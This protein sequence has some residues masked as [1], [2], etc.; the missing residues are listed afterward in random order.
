MLV[1]KANLDFW[2]KNNYNVLFS[3]RHGVGKTA[4]IL[5]AFN[6]HDL[7]WLYFSAATMDPW[8]DFIGVPK[9][10]TDENGNSYLDLIRPKAFMEDEVQAL[11]FDE[12]NRSSKKVRNAVMEL[13]QFKS[14]NGKRF[15]NLKV[16]WAAINPEEEGEYDVEALDPAQVDRFHIFLDIP[17][18]PDAQYFRKKYDEEIA[19][20][21]IEWWQNQPDEIKAEVSPRRLDYTLD[22]FSNGGDI[23]FVLPQKANVTALLTRIASGP[24]KKKLKDYLAKGDKVGAKDFLE[25]ENNYSAAI[26]IILKDSAFVSFY[27]PLL[28][29][30]K[31][32]GLFATSRI[33][34][35]HV[36]KNASGYQD[37]LT[38]IMNAGS[39]KEARLARN[40][41]GP[42]WNEPLKQVAWNPSKG[43]Q[44]QV[45]QATVM[46][47]GNTYE[48]QKTYDDIVQWM[49]LKIKDPG[50]VNKTF[51]ALLNIAVSC[52][53]A[54][55]QA[56]MPMLGS[57]LMHLRKD[58]T[59]VQITPAAH[60][61]CSRKLGITI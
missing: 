2:I 29:K 44:E 12:F 58:V 55:I 32:A 4:T 22:V 56:K 41:V 1:N 61:A 59:R 42:Y 3:G 57:M 6:D 8:V 43:A 25:Q 39:G 45:L 46:P 7:K 26:E 37:L 34:Q 49:P 54:T 36:S 19:A 27:Y 30:E 48:R 21:A 51:R 18:R 28:H 9:E 10:R 47:T 60:Q 15:E 38:D 23:R 17:Y 13:I 52:Q 40:I 5:E 53:Y 35:T 14:I 24:V 31:Q 50:L 33:V 11:F 16:V 20:A